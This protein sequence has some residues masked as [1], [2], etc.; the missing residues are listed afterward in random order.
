[1]AAEIVANG[2]K[3]LDVV[4]KVRGCKYL[5]K[6]TVTFKP[7]GHVFWKSCIYW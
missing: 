5:I 7:D 3:S 6:E 2:H 4:S 1:M